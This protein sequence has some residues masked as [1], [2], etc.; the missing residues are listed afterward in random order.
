MTDGCNALPES[1]AGPN[2]A[3]DDAV[4]EWVVVIAGSTD[5]HY[6]PFALPIITPDIRRDFV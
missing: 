6:V 2:L 5:L 1:G 4:A 3:F